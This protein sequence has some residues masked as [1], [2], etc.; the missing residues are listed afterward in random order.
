M[1]RVA[2]SIFSLIYQYSIMRIDRLL[3]IG[4][5]LLA[6]FIVV[7][8][9]LLLTYDMSAMAQ[10]NIADLY[11]VAKSVDE[12]NKTLF[13]ELN[14]KAESVSKDI[15]QVT[16]DAAIE[17]LRSV[18]NSIAAK[19]KTVMDV[20]FVAVRDLVTTI[21]FEKTDAEQHGETPSRERIE[22]ILRN[23]LEQNEHVKAVF[24]CWEK[25]QF[26][27]K[28]ADF[29]GK[30]NPDPEM[31]NL[32]KEYVSEG[33]FLPWFYLD[34]DKETK[35]TK[36]VRA[37][38]DDYLAEPDNYYGATR[39]TKQEHITEPYVD[40][41][42][43]IT[44]FCVPILK[45][46]KF[47]GMAGIDIALGKLQEIVKESRPFENGF[48]M[49]LSPGQEI[50]Y[51][52]NEKINYTTQKNYDDVEEQCYRKI[53][54]V[55]ALKETAMYVAEKSTD[56]YTSKTMTGEPG[57]EML[58]VHIPVQFGN[59]PELWTV[60]IV[61]PVTDVMRQRNSVKKSMDDMV[62]GLETQN[63]QFVETLENHITSVIET[64][65]AAAKESL[66]RAG[67]V[68]AVVLIVSVLI[69]CIFA[70][71]VNRSIDARDFRYRQ[72]LDACN[73][74][75]SVVDMNFNITFIN[76]P[77]LELLKREFK[78]CVGRSVE[79]LWKPIIGGDYEHCGIRFL[80]STG[81]TLSHVIFLGGHWDVTSNYITEIHGTKDGLIEIFNDVSDRENIYHLIERVDELIKS[82]V[83]QTTSIVQAAEDMSQGAN[84]QAGS[85]ESITTDMRQMNGQTEKN[86]AY[87]GNANTLSGSAAQSATLGQQRMQE[88]VTAMNQIS[89]NAKN[90][91]NVIKT[92]DDIAFQTNL[93]ALN[94]A[95]EAA[96]AGSHGKG[97]AVVAEEVRNLA[98]RSAKAAKETED[99]I[100]KSNQQIEGGVTVAGQ[101]ADALNN[102]AQ[103]VAD[104]SSLISSIA[105]AS[106]EQ[107]TGVGRMTD[108]LQTVDQITK[109]N[110]E[111]S[112]T[113]TDAAQQ[114]SLEVKELQSLMEKLQ[115]K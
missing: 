111:L 92:I 47:L 74:P 33:A 82:T 17:E 77:G 31:D 24:S 80:R 32:Y 43:P 107:T 108:M 26:D 9:T 15:W 51:H 98:A 1:S 36:I 46:D 76:K 5:V 20:P 66:Y 61:A 56:I 83:K 87:A 65:Q 63:A 104:V 78:E 72:I 103:H 100:V 41:G 19:I 105:S 53:E 28:D 113:T 94:A 11:S 13:T 86:A 29:V 75:I 96:R 23:Y 99:L 68:A 58:V 12:Q 97:F 10:R 30:E 8:I 2:F 69:G 37:Y 73:D 21:M 110:V 3:L 112:S 67:A 6:V 38:C 93:L 62:K 49:L 40:A 88:M 90:M 48:A 25:N 84:R 71:R 50:I 89:D 14:Q 16:N 106:Q 102:I 42:S 39:S 91:R 109:H 60:V 81:Q 34:E 4:I 57:E 55:D 101:T 27:G 59:Y 79:E 18:G 35:K 54:T 95:V 115:K 44:S 45:D 52:P 85:V 64:S 70:G 7:I 114:L 22:R